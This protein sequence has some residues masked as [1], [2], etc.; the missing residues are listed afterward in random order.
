MSENG[1]V[2]KE[3]FFFSLSKKLMSRGDK[4]LM[5]GDQYILITCKLAYLS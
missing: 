5:F 3:N 1:V 4:E 2:R